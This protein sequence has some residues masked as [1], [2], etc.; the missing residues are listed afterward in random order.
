MSPMSCSEVVSLI[1]EKRRLRKSD[2]GTLLDMA[3]IKIAG[4]SIVGNV[5]GLPGVKR[6]TGRPE[7][8]NVELRDIDFS[9]SDLGEAMFLGGEISNCVFEKAKCRN[10]GFWGVKV[11]NCSFVGA[12]LRDS[13]LGSFGEHCKTQNIFTHTVFDGSNLRG[14]IHSAEIFD[15][16]H[17]RKATLKDVMF[18]CTYFRDCVFE[19]LL[20]DVTFLKSAPWASHLPENKLE[21]CDF[22]HCE[23]RYVDFRNI[24]LVG[25][26]LPTDR[27]HILLPRGPR[28]WLEWLSR[29]DH[30]TYDRVREYVELMA[31][32]AGT[33]SIIAESDLSM[34]F[35]KEQIDLLRRVA[36]SA[37]VG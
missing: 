23:L 20:E 22:S 5:K 19:G 14:S 4:P 11:S 12:D 30:K 24:D 21:R 35:S 31:S 16:C 34:N 33:P 26:G 3:K 6:I 7:F 2:S 29:L 17:F 25:I 13:V 9:G 1:S 18:D 36:S 27:K 32:R 8:K 37:K 10:I 28:D 15:N